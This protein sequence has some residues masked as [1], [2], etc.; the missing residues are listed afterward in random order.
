M[1]E[2]RN[3]EGYDGYQISNNGRVRSRVNNRHGLSDTYHEIKSVSNEHGYETVQLG[4]RN[5]K[6]ISRLVA[7]AFI[8]NPNN[9]PLVRHLDDNTHNNNVD[10]LAWGTQK[11]NMQDCVKHNRLIGDTRSAIESRKKKVLAKTIDG[12]FVGTFSSEAEACRKLNIKSNHICDNIKGKIKQTY[13]Y[14]F[15]YV[16]KEVK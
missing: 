7:E 6:L 15:E 11:D 12:K 3:I 14:V 9:L 2:W 1:I 10:N 5:R 8:P 16:D 4:R 13:G